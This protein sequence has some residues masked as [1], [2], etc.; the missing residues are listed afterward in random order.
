VIIH[1]LPI[2]SGS[3]STK[4]AGVLSANIRCV[5]SAKLWQRLN[6][7][8]QYNFKHMLHTFSKHMLQTFKKRK[9]VLGSDLSTLPIKI[10]AVILLLCQSKFW[11]VIF[12][13]CQSKFWQWSFLLCQS[14]FWQ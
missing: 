13:L 12:L 4:S 11:A 10:L 3:R 6:E 14:K 2:I 7:L 1:N 8:C 9:K 5:R